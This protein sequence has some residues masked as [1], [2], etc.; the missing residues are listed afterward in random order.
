MDCLYLTS[1]FFINLLGALSLIQSCLKPDAN[2]RATTK[3][4]LHHDWLVHGPVLSIRLNSIPTSTTATSSSSSILSFPSEQQQQQQ[5]QAPISSANDYENVRLRNIT[6]VKNSLSPSNSLAELELQTSAFFDSTRLREN[7]I[8][9]KEQQRRNRVSA[10]PI[11]TRYLSSNNIK[12]NNAALSRPT[13][14]R[15]V[16][17]SLDDP[18][19]LQ[20]DTSQKQSVTFRRTGSPS[21]LTITTPTYASNDRFH[22]SN[23]YTFTRSPESTTASTTT[24]TPSRYL[25]SDFDT[26]LKDIKCKEIYKYTAPTTAVAPSMFTTSA[27]KFAP[28]PSR[29]L[30]PTRDEES[31][32]SAR[33]N[34]I[35]P[36]STTTTNPRHSLIT[37]L[38][39]PNT[40][41]SRFLDDNN[42][43]VSLK[44]SE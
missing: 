25:S 20:Q 36:A 40:Y 16:S 39:L 29:R 12:S 7:S 6:P 32:N 41:R 11:S 17:L 14:R 26:T 38:E 19:P 1:V 37:S 42:N 31:T 2:N 24:T 43:L 23:R 18:Q 27:I 13:Y 8:G 44:V 9:T 4:I 22:S 33:D 5:Q 28:V 34:S 21:A 30:S 15:P 3:D 35:N 10:I